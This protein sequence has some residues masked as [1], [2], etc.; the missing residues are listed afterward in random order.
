MNIFVDNFSS[1]IEYLRK[2]AA[3]EIITQEL[4]SVQIKVYDVLG[5]EI[6]KLVSEEKQPGNYQAEFN[7]SKLSSGVYFYKLQLGTT[8]IN[9]KMLLMK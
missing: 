9:K 8:V 1:P 2:L 4:V 7:G 3:R 5:K 6:S